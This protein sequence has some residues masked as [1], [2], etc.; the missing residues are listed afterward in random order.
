MTLRCNICS[1][2]IEEKDLE[3]HLNLQQH[4]ENKERLAK[5]IEKGLD[6]SIVGKWLESVK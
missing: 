3:A 1:Q 2:E 5:R 4:K 6:V